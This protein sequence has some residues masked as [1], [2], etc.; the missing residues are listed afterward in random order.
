MTISSINVI[1]GWIAGSIFRYFLTA[2]KNTMCIN[3]ICRNDMSTFTRAMY[4]S[5][6]SSTACTDISSSNNG[7]IDAPN[8]K[9]TTTFIL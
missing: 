7:C 8:S 1:R 3:M 2:I 6:S 4:R 5:T 9:D